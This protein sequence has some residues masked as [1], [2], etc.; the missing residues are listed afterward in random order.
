MAVPLLKNWRCS[1]FY[2]GCTITLRI[3]GGDNSAI[4]SYN[5]LSVWTEYMHH[6]QWSNQVQLSWAKWSWPKASPIKYAKILQHYIYISN[7]LAFFWLR[8]KFSLATKLRLLILLGNQIDLVTWFWVTGLIWSP[9]TGWQDPSGHPKRWVTR[10][11][12][13]LQWIIIS[14]SPILRWREVGPLLI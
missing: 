9:K 2:G 3:G 5:M 12:W 11:I 7:I 10:S 14:M 13:L 8:K 6:S 4:I 1:F